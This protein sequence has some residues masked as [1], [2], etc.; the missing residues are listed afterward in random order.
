MTRRTRRRISRRLVLAL[1]WFAPLGTGSAV[2]IMCQADAY[3]P[4]RAELFP[5]ALVLARHGR[6]GMVV[7][8]TA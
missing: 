5:A 7:G 4:T 6:R 3:A 1:A 2:V 8:R